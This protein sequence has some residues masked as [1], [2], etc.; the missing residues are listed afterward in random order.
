MGRRILKSK[1]SIKDC[2]LQYLNLDELMTSHIENSEPD[3]T[4][5]NFTGILR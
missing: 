5:Y 4:L 2:G 1:S 3:P